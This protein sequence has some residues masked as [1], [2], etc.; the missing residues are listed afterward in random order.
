M[1][2]KKPLKICLV[3]SARSIH[4]QR[5]EAFL[6]SHG[7]EVHILTNFP[8]KVVKQRTWHLLNK[9]KYGVAAY[10]FSI[11]KFYYLIRNIRPDIIH[12]HYVGGPSIYSLVINHLNT[13]IIVSPWGNDVYLGSS[14]VRKMLI[15]KLF[16]SAVLIFTTSHDMSKH[17][18]KFF[19]I[20]PTKIMTISWG[21]DVKLF[22]PPSLN[23]KIKLREE[24]NIPKSSFVVFS[25]R[26]MTPVYQV[27]LIVRAFLSIIEK[28]K[29]FFLLLLEG[30][31]S[32]FN[33][34]II[35]YRRKIKEMIK[36]KE[37]FI[38]IIKGF[39]SPTIM[40]QYLKAS[41]VVFSIPLSDQRSTSVLE[42]LACCPIVILSSIP[43][44][45]ELQEEGYKVII[46]REFTID[47]VEEIIYLAKSLHPS[48]CKDWIQD[49]Y[50]IILE[51]ENW[52]IQATKVEM[53]YY[54]CL[55]KYKSM[56]K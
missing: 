49:N 21:I 52:E 34:K 4:I 2:S 23:E 11:F 9:E 33:H 29:D 30:T 38:K 7:H 6:S 45:L 18:Q 3:G 13:P 42:G 48:T 17:I 19:N 37:N 10:L 16:N 31:E 5:W 26:S 1:N 46:L 27:D 40:S 15:Q 35:R 54:N 44:Y 47:N 8:S 32:A 12:F 56:R 24:L 20:D 41:D 36:N 51:R 43:P 55:E 25:N 53:E 50:R 28:R 39:I 22:H 14:I